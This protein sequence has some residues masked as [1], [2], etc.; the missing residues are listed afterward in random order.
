MA[1]K[2]WRKS[3]L[4]EKRIQLL[5]Q[6]TSNINISQDMDLKWAHQ[7]SIVALPQFKIQPLL[8]GQYKIH[9]HRTK[10]RNE[11]GALRSILHTLLILFLTCM[12][13]TPISVR[14]GNAIKV[15]QF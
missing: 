10:Q 9:S 14:M 15:H 8:L 11:N 7:I 5:C 12:I 2:T 4:C 1:L 6:K 3:V 13:S